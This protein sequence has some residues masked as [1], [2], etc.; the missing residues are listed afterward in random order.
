MTWCA[1]TD[2]RSLGRRPPSRGILAILAMMLGLVVAL[3][4]LSS[5]RAD[6]GDLEVEITDVAPAVVTTGDDLVISGRIH[7][8][9]GDELEAPAVRLLLQLHVPS[10][11]ETLASWLDG[12]SDSTSR[13]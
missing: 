10:S 4:P 6:D 9:T 3:V 2:A 7:N 11:A 12:T 8:R 5:A 1:G 13:R